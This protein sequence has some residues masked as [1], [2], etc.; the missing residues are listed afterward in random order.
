MCSP[1][2]QVFQWILQATSNTIHTSHFGSHASWSSYPLLLCADGKHGHQVVTHVS[3]V[4]N[5]SNC[6]KETTPTSYKCCYSYVKVKSTKDMQHKVSNILINF[7][8]TNITW[9]NY[10]THWNCKT[11]GLQD[12]WV[13]PSFLL[14]WFLQMRTQH[15]LISQV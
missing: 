9:V 8:K 3:I 4:F 12:G 13:F 7:C 2:P 1:L 5:V 6:A 11:K 15:C 14:N 10:F